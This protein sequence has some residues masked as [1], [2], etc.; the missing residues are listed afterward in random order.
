[1]NCIYEINIQ[2][3]YVKYDPFIIGDV[4]YQVFYIPYPHDVPYKENWWTTLINKARHCPNMQ[5]DVVKVN[6][7][8]Q[9]D[10]MGPTS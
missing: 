8:F 5:G 1:L 7:V 4:A 10:V 2:C 6:P 9:E 3:K